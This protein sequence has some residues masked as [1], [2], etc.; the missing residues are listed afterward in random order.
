MKGPTQG[1]GVNQ[2]GNG[3]IFMKVGTHAGE[4]LPDIIE[5]KTLELKRAGVSFWGYGGNTCHPLSIVQPFVE[6]RFAAGHDVRL[7]MNPM[8]SKHFAAQE[9]AKEYSDDGVRWQRVP[10]DVNVLGSRYALVLSS[11][12][13]DDFDVDLASLRVALGSR[14]GAPASEYVQGRVD[15]GC[16]IVGSDADHRGVDPV[17]RHIGLVA[18][19]ARPYA[20]LLR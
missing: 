1:R 10:R 18:S 11:L 2:P 14:Q 20:V 7:V 6:S 16:F 12:D 3:V 4:T 9:V 13:V 5:R 8:D 19:L 17:P 15:K